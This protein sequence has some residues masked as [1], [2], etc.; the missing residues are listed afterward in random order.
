MIV[1]TIYI[2][3]WDYAAMMFEDDFWWVENI[4][5]LEWTKWTYETDDIYFDYEIQE[6]NVIDFDSFEKWFNMASSIQEY[7]DGKHEGIYII[8]EK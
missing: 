8:N 5:R 4:S 7:D 1:K 2:N 6:H 3:W